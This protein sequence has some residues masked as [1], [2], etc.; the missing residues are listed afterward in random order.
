MP[1]D[2]NC[3]VRR[4]AASRS[5][6]H[7]EFIVRVNRSWPKFYVKKNPVHSAFGQKTRSRSTPSASP[8]PVRPDWA[9]FRKCRKELSYVN[10]F[11]KGFILNQFF[12]FVSAA[13]SYLKNI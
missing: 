3:V 2:Q 8:P 4:R 6:A 1:R 12:A 5:V 11:K 10:L 13:I 9:K 7:L